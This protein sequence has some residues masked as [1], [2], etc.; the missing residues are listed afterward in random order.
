MSQLPAVITTVVPLSQKQVVDFRTQLEKK[1]GQSIV[2][3]NE[4]EPDIIGGVRLTL[5]SQQYDASLGQQLRHIKQ[6]LLN[7]S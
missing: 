2:L 3:T 1:L 5:G 7:L 6:Q 4:V